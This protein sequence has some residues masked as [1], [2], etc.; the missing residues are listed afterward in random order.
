M[1]IG[2]IPAVLLNADKWDDFVIFLQSLPV[3][4]QSKKY[5]IIE[6]C[7]LTGVALTGDLVTDVLGYTH[8]RMA[9]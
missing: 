4:A 1:A 3:D 8:Y 6:W 2:I 7:Q 5:L 9:G